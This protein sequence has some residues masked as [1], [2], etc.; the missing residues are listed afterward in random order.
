MK[1]LLEKDVKG[2]GKKGDLIEVSDAYARNVLL[3]KGL[4]VEANAGNMNNYKLRKQNE[5]KVAAEN[6]AAAKELSAAL[7]EKVI[8]IPIKVGG[9][10]RAFGAVQSKEIA[11]AVKE[12]TGLDIDKKK[13]VLAQPIK[14]LGEYKVPVKLHPDVSASLH[15]VIEELK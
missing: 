7:K 3:K 6:L 10:G 2:K 12:Q 9:A 5:A 13:L 14:N 1:V 8:R 11:D 15:L 4:A